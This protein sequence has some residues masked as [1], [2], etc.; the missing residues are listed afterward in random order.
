MFIFAR[1][2]AVQNN[3]VRVLGAAGLEYWSNVYRKIEIFLQNLQAFGLSI[4]GIKGKLFGDQKRFGFH[5]SFF[6][7]VRWQG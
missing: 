3:P 2:Q 4:S 7:P 1:S 5:Y 6:G